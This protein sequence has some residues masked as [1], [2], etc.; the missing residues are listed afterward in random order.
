MFLM[1][2]TLVIQVELTK[3]LSNSEL[4]DKPEEPTESVQVGPIGMS[5]SSFLICYFLLFIMFDMM[6]LSFDIDCQPMA[7][8]LGEKNAMKYRTQKHVWKPERDRVVLVDYY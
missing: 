8:F 4:L 6:R 3:H 7:I 5:G 2:D 1:D